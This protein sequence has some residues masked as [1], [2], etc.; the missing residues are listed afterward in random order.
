MAKAESYLNAKKPKRAQ[1]LLKQ[2]YGIAP[3]EPAVTF[4]LGACLYEIGNNSEALSY[5][6]KVADQA[7]QQP[8]ILMHLL[9]PLVNRAC[10]LNDDQKLISHH[11]NAL[12][13]NKFIQLFGKIGRNLPQ[14]GIFHNN[15]IIW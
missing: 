5:I 14:F 15:L 11:F 2:L 7:P 8:N 13:C 4:N 6:K 1:P 3:H 9:V 10:F 12:I